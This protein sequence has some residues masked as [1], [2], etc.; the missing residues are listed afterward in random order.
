MR[1]LLILAAVA[2]V[3]YFGVPWAAPE[4]LLGGIQVN[5]ADHGAWVAAL[6][7]A[8]MNAVAVTVYAR[9]GDWD[10]ENLWYEDEEPWVLHEVREARRGGLDAVLVLRVALDHAYERN[11]FF[12]HGMISPRGDDRLDE[13]FRRYTEFV[14]RWAAIAEREGIAVLAVGSELN[15]L[16][17]TTVL[18]EL[19]ELEE[20]YANAEKV[21]SENAR[22]L[23][24]REAVEQ[25]HLWVRG[26][27]PQGSLPEFLDE[28]S[29]AERQWARQ[30]AFLDRDD[31]LAA[32]NARRAD[33]DARW[34]R[35]V[36]QARERYGGR[37]TY[38]ANFDQYERV[39]FWDA[40][41]EIGV[42]AYFPLRRHVLPGAGAGE[43]GAL[44]E[45]R[46]RAV[47]RRLD[48][49]RRARGLGD[50]RFLFTE[51]GYVRRANATI[52][53]W[54]SHGFSVL[55]SPA[56]ERL[57]IW[58]EQPADLG[59]RALAVRGLYRANLALGGDLLSGLLYWKLSTEPAH[60]EV[61]PF[62][63]VLGAGD[64][65]EGELAAFTG[66]LPWDRLRARLSAALPG[67]S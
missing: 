39:A 28:R 18:E 49:F 27:D 29:R 6:D 47:L 7:G 34:R 66:R 11:K 63:L 15:A 32:V 24:H 36:A 64:P 43:L 37:L 1:K 22:L 20:Y 35:L 33:L 54:A 23:A 26:Y 44:L 45:A 60:A 42:N 10:S 25:K 53:P 65:L 17:N 61:E 59:E 3:V 4:F 56:G 50:H 12:W 9:Q 41:D 8:G 51:L 58:Q 48:D 30:V 31:P 21:A 40:L 14:L 67:G 38:A 19:P 16:T 2:A 46:W 52:E 13:W 55:P 62:V 57:V 5:E